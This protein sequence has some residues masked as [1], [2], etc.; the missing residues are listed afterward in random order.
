MA[1]R[2]TVKIFVASSG[3]LAEE[4]QCVSVL[5]DELNKQ[6]NHLHLEPVMFELDMESGN[7][8]GKT[9]IQDEINPL[10]DQSDIV[11]VLFYSRAGAFTKEEF[12]RATASGK[13]IF[14]YRK[15]GFKSEDPTELE[16]YLDLMKMVQK[17]EDSSKMRYL[18]FE[19]VID[20][21]GLLY[22]DLDKY[23]RK[24]YPE[25]S[26]KVAASNGSSY[27]SIP[28]SL[29]PFI[30][31]PYGMPKG[32]TGRKVEMDSLSEWFTKD[33][34]NAIYVLE[35]IGGMGKTS[36]T[37]KWVQSNIINQ[38]SEFSGIFW[39]SFYDQGFERFI[40][41]LHDYCLPKSSMKSDSGQIDPIRELL[42]VLANNRFLI[43]M[44]GF[45][46]ILRGYNNLSAMDVR[47]GQ[48]LR[49]D[50]E[51]WDLVQRSLINPKAE[52]FIEGLTS[53]KSKI[54]ITTRLFPSVLDDLAGVKHFRLTGLSKEDTLEFFNCEKIEGTTEEILRAAAVYGYHPLMLKLLMS[55]LKRSLTKNIRDAFGKKIIVQNEPQKIF[56]ESFDILNDREKS[57][58]ARLSVLRSAFEFPAARALAP[59]FEEEQT[60]L[61][62]QE[63]SKLGFILFEEMDQKFDLHPVMRSFLYDRLQ[64]KIEIHELAI[65]HLRQV[66]SDN[67]TTKIDLEPAIE[68]FH[69]LIRVGKFDEAVVLYSKKPLPVNDYGLIL[70]L[71]SEAFDHG[72]PDKPLLNQAKNIEFAA[73]HLGYSHINNGS[74]DLGL[75]FFIKHN[76][77]CEVVTCELHQLDVHESLGSLYHT[78]QTLRKLL[79]RARRDFLDATSEFKVL[80]RISKHLH[81][82]GVYSFEEV[83]EKRM[84]KI[85]D[86]AIS[87][88]QL[89]TVYLPELLRLRFYI[90]LRKKNYSQCRRIALQMPVKWISR[91]YLG[92]IASSRGD[93]DLAIKEYESILEYF[94]STGNV[95]NEHFVLLTLAELSERK[96]ESLVAANLLKYPMKYAVRTGDKAMLA[97]GHNLMAKISKKQGNNEDAALNATKAYHLAWCNGR[98]YSFQSHLDEATKILN[99]LKVPCPE[100][101]DTPELRGAR[102]FTMSELNPIGPWRVIP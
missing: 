99:E 58:A 35:A 24:Q 46:R 72:D 57:V 28:K 13:K 54:V 62:L 2:K 10:V 96:S 65:N 55:T 76:E 50:S 66:S 45:E 6:F 79:E 27:T 23:L 95:K 56:F 68:L 61:I 38:A 94:R 4:R 51:T 3:E 90:A 41:M 18:Q 26:N 43:V 11:I 12:E 5:L 98:A 53:G 89:E 80:N 49:D 91:N 73:L 92:V 42:S 70:K 69:H 14:L 84:T 17:I 20:F 21:N 37:W 75:K 22:K 100:L 77:T 34:E 86:N 102:K 101:D 44:D 74:P 39:W 8:P 88:S 63:L 83:L 1:E 60:W 93:I 30:A 15:K 31:H 32:F 64:N 48:S 82:R 97:D 7:Y 47:E 25:E 40:E 59:D 16:K 71:L 52:R 67:A 85:F 87:Q 19:K 81:L 33:K 78:E 29:Q 36:L 9:R